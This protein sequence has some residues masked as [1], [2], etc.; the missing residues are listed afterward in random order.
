[1]L[2]TPG[3]L[4]HSAFLNNLAG[5]VKTRFD[6]IFRYDL[7]TLCRSKTLHDINLALNELSCGAQ[8]APVIYEIELQAAWAGYISRKTAWED[9]AAA[10]QV[11]IDLLRSPSLPILACP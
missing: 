2:Q 3:T 6:L 9:A 5:A 1:M 11:A 7:A 8:F 10:Y 4:G